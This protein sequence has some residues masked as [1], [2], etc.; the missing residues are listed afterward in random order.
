MTP[1][2]KR[3]V[4]YKDVLAEYARVPKLLV[5]RVLNA[6]YPWKTTLEQR[7]GQW[8]TPMEIQVFCLGECAIVA[9]AAEVFNEI[10]VS[11]KEDSPAPI[12]LFA[13]YSNGCIGYLPTEAA[14]ALG[15]QT[16]GLWI[17]GLERR[18]SSVSIDFNPDFIWESD[19]RV[20]EDGWMAEIRIPY[21]SL[22]FRPDDSQ[23]WGFNVAREVKRK[24]A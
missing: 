16:D 14:H 18:G 22:R 17:E 8:H 2:G 1:D 12:T 24:G 13:G 11:I 4:T 7:D 19:G 6:R 21:V 20:T 23:S 9:H 3:R 10:G 5:D 15:I